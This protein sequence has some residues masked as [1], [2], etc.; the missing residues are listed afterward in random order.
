MC[1]CDGQPGL[2]PCCGGPKCHQ[3]GCTALDRGACICDAPY[4]TKAPSSRP[5]N[6]GPRVR[7]TFQGKPYDLSLHDAFGLLRGVQAA[8][9]ATRVACRTCRCRV[10]PGAECPC[11]ASAA[12]LATIDEGET[13]E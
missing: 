8:I 3:K 11:C 2:P 12:I 1:W 4:W 13:S 9:D 6:A 10:L 7:F 5:P